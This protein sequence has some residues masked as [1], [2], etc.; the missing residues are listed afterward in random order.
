VSEIQDRLQQALAERYTIQRELGRGGMATVYLATDLKHDRE[1]AIKVLHPELAATIGPER[2]DREIRIAAKLQHPNILGL[3]DS[4]EANGLLYYVMPFIFGESLR[5][6]LNRE[7]MLPVDAA[8]HIALEVADALGYAHSLGIVHRDIKPENIMISGGHALVADFGIARAASGASG[9]AKLTETGMAVG[10]PLYMSPEQAVGEQVGPTAD[11]YSLACVLYEMLTGHPPFTG[12]NARQIMA[13]HAMDAVPSI[14]VVR[15]TVPDQVEDAVMAALNK[16]VADRPQ[17]A[18]QF[19][20]MLGSPMGATAARYTASRAIPRRSVARMAPEGAVTLTLKKRSLV[21]VGIS[22]VAGLLVLGGLLTWWLI[23]PRDGSAVTTGGINPHSIAVLYFKDETAKQ[24]L[25]VLADGLTENLISALG[26]VQGLNVVSPGGVAQFRGAQIP[27]D[28]V[29]RALQVGT[30]V[31]GSVDEEG[32][33]V[34][35]TL[36]MLDDGGVELDKVSF[37]GA[38]KDVATLS[39]SLAQEAATLIRKRVGEEAQLSR[40][41]AGTRSTDAWTMLQ[42]AV[43]RRTRGD[44]LSRAGNAEGFQ[45]E[46]HAADSLAALAEGFDPKWIAPIV[47]RGTLAYWRSRVATSDPGLARRIVDSGV[48][49]AERALAI[50][51]NSAEAL[52]LRGNLNYWRALVPLESDTNRIAAILASARTDLER[53]RDLNPRSAWSVATL[54]HLYANAPDKTLVD[55]VLAASEAL[56]RDAYLSNAD[57]VINRLFHAHYDL[58]Q[59]K[60][61]EHW[62]QEGHRRFP[63][64]Y[65]FVECQLLMMS[66]KWVDKPSPAQAW[67]LADSTVRLTTN[68]SDRRLE[69]LYTRVLVAGVLARAGDKDS[70]KRV[71]RATK[72]DP[73]VDPSADVANTAAF[74]WTLTGD[75]TEAINQIRYYLL[76]NPNRKPDFRNNPNWWFK[77]LSER[78]DYQ[79][80]VR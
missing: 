25:G 16:V 80:L 72:N 38:G 9:S 45:Q 69:Q 15:D 40:T 10:T 35:V 57:Q 62:C 12:S 4:G 41:R 74:I 3:F 34:R 27:R 70:A 52:E 55:V 64:D 65:R 61:A 46:Y 54:S 63:R 36:R 67:L 22:A 13:R 42:R 48:T 58:E 5:D 73:E 33:K 14:Q 7:H 32:D 28:S 77:R 6:R 21:G 75:T 8:I 53:A 71:L 79:A 43:Q 51:R 47:L 37:T 18:A 30:L 17:T 23:R 56:K 31:Q 1:V 66:T 26:S 39:D 60:D 29:A 20:E 24:N 11:L 19:S 76:T 78:P 68:E 59:F 2:F 44:S 50:D 49:H